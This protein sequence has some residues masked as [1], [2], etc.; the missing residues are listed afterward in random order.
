VVICKL[1]EYIKKL[2]K[3]IAIKPTME[4][5]WDIFGDFPTNDY[6]ELNAKGELIG[7]TIDKPPTIGDGEQLVFDEVIVI[8]LGRYF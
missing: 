8:S 7:W 2:P 1:S 4:P 5:Y 6:E 3:Y